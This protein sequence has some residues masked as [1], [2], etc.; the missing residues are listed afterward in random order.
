MWAWTQD[1]KL[2]RISPLIL[3]NSSFFFFFFLSRCSLSA[4]LLQK[5][6]ISDILTSSS[7]V[8]LDICS[9]ACGREG[10]EYLHR[11]DLTFFRN[12]R[13]F[14]VF[15]QVEN[16]AFSSHNTFEPY[17]ADPFVI[18]G[19][20]LHSLWGKKSSECVCRRVTCSLWFGVRWNKVQEEKKTSVK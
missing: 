9:S 7:L 11:Q 8:L 1:E 20:C 16:F 18:A 10:W 12:M 3:K 17:F 15:A 2:R 14:V 6:D 5:K 13:W 19:G 4:Q